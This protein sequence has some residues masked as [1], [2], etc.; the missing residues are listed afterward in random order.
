MAIIKV[1]EDQ[2]RGTTA[3]FIFRD[4]SGGNG[5]A[6]HHRGSALEDQSTELH[7]TARNFWRRLRFKDPL[8]GVHVCNLPSLT[9]AT[10]S[11]LHAELARERWCPCFPNLLQLTCN[12]PNQLLPQQPAARAAAL[13][14][15]INISSGNRLR[16]IPK[17]FDRP[18]RRR[19]GSVRRDAA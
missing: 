3:A 8:G 18:D 17:G 5:P 13:G 4:N 7:R 1:T 10:P 11:W 6:C 12:T 15:C 19:T 16:F 14:P 9:F 2:S